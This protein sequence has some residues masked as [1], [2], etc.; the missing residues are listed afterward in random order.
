MFN[1]IA[2]KLTCKEFY[3]KIRFL[4]NHTAPGLNGITSEDIKA[5]DSELTDILFII[6]R[7]YINDKI[8]IPGWHWGNIC[9]LPKHGDLTSPKTW[10]GINLLDKC[11]KMMSMIITKIL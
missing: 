8:D 2:G 10:C 9:V 11:S 1:G 6:I 3:D 7:D 4:K 5:L